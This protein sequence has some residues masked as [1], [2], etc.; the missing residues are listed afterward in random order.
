MHT[1][2]QIKVSAKDFESLGQKLEQ[3][4]ASLSPAEAHVFEFFI[5]NAAAA[6]GQFP[7][8]PWFRPHFRYKP[9]GGAGLV[10]GGVDG[11]TILIK[12]NGKI[13]V[14]PPI[15]PLSLDRSGLLAAIPISGV[16]D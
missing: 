15:G 6:A 8:P 7:P 11:F 13:I 4:H 3:L 12:S 5:E 14:V 9:R 2:N 1:N 16:S 10:A